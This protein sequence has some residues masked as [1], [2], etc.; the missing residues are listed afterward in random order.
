MSSY[1]CKAIHLARVIHLYLKNNDI[2]LKGITFEKIDKMSVIK[3]LQKI[4]EKN[5]RFYK[6]I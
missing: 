3:N 4:F 6:C 2:D 5:I 1:Y